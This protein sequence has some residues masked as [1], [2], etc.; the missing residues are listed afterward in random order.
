MVISIMK[1]MLT[2]TYLPPNKCYQIN[3]FSLKHVN[4]TTLI[5]NSFTRLSV[6]ENDSLAFVQIFSTY[7]I[8]KNF[9]Y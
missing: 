1:S 5:S 7:I 4:T 3:L 2:K 9:I 8:K 6:V